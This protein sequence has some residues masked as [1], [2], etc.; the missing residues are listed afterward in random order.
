VTSE[1]IAERTKVPRGYVSKVLRDLVVAELIDSQRG[2]KGGFCLARPPSRITILDVIRAVDS[3][4][5]IRKCPLGNP[6]H[7]QLCPLHRRLDEAIALVEREFERTS[8]AEVLETNAK[9]RG[10]CAALVA[11]TIRKTT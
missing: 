3:I 1:I 11:P 8:L 4:P 2:R 7:V 6:A 9:A 5:R 10:A